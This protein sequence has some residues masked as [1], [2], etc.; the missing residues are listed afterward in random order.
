M[1]EKNTNNGADNFG[2]GEISTIRNIL[3]GQQMTEYEQ[4]F[5]HLEDKLVAASEEQGEKLTTFQKETEEKLNNLE[6]EMS[7]RFDSLEKM[8]KEG[9]ENLQSQTQSN[10]SNDNEELGKMLAEVGQKLMQK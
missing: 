9:L 8:L 7:A 10:R 2:L 4:R 1:A 5:G 6:K 3:M